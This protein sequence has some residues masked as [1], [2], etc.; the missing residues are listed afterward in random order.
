MVIKALK[1]FLNFKGGLHKSPTS[2]FVSRLFG[3]GIEIDLKV[4]SKN[5]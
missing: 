3:L 1:V 4:L 5:Y 2:D